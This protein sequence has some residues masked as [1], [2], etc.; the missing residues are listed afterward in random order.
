[1]LGRLEDAFFQQIFTDICPT[2]EDIVSH[3]LIYMQSHEM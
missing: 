3:H 1:M 2:S